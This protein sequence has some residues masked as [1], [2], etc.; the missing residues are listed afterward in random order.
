MQETPSLKDILTKE[1]KRVDREIE[2]NNSDLIII[3]LVN[4]KDGIQFTLDL[5]KKGSLNA[6][7]QRRDLRGD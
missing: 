1:I 4:Y 5:L 2:K 7:E 6:G 3:M